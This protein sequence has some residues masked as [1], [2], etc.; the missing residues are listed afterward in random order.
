VA[1]SKRATIEVQTRL[2]MFLSLDVVGS[3][4]F[5]QSKRGADS[6]EAA[7]S[8]VEPFLSFYQIAVQQMATQWTAVRDAIAA[9]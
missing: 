5:K 3:T 4:E 1:R 7:D 8:W 2:R 6:A 9:I